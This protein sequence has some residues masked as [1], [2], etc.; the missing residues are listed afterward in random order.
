VRSAQAIANVKRICEEYLSG[1]YH[2]EIVDLYQQPELAAGHQILAAPTLLKTHPAP[3]R[4]IIGDMSRT[5]RLLAGLH[6]QPPAGLAGGG[7]A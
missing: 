4:R 1:S 6:L 3:L 5:D 7:S 2:L